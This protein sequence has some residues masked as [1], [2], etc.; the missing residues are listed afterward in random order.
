MSTRLFIVRH[1]ESVWNAAQR[2]QGQADPPLSPEG[3]RQAEAL[4]EVLSPRPISA[5]YSSP[6]RRAHL[7]AAAIAAPHELEPRLEAALREIHLGEW[8]GLP[9]SQ[10]VGELLPARPDWTA[11]A[12]EDESPD[13]PAMQ[14]PGGESLAQ[15][16]ERVAPVLTLLASRHRGE[17]IVLVTHS[18]IGRVALSHLLGMGLG[19]VPRLKLKVASISMVRIDEDGAVLE[20]LGDTGHLRSASLAALA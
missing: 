11:E 18:V 4:A 1:A 8:Q 5:V 7:T 12:P 19:L 14:A 2:I 15:G 9:F 17:T 6:L 16:L 3:R 13:D 20:R 10:S